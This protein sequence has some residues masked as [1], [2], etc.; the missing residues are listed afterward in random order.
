MQKELEFRIEVGRRALR[1]A[2][3]AVR[4]VGT[5]G[6]RFYFNLFSIFNFIFTFLKFIFRSFKIFKAY[7]MIYC[8]KLEFKGYQN[9]LELELKNEMRRRTESC[10]NVTENAPTRTA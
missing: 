4:R 2:E 8:E 3:H 7:V 5:R 10:K 9:P 6:Y 1:H